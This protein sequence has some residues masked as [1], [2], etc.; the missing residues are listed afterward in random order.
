MEAKVDND[1]MSKAREDGPPAYPKSH[2]Q[3]FLAFHPLRRGS[4]SVSIF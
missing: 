3:A 1:H 4:F 2:L